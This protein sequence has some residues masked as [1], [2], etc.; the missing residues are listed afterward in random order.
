M[1]FLAR[2][3]HG[4]GPASCAG[5]WENSIAL[6]VPCVLRLCLRVSNFFN[7]ALLVDWEPSD[8]NSMLEKFEE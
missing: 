7:I 4:E 6:Q 2:P 8:E 5:G 3:G 1:C